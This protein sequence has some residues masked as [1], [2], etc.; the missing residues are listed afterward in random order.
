MAKVA[1]KA[2]AR[3]ARSLGLQT[4]GVYS[5][6]GASMLRFACWRGCHSTL[7]IWIDSG[8]QAPMVTFFLFLLDGITGKK[9]LSYRSDFIT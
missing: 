6:L 4:S 7:P 3:I 5:P 8:R 2:Q 1:V 9:N